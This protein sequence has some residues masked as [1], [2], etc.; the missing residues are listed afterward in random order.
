MFQ[1]AFASMTIQFC[2]WERVLYLTK[3]HLRINTNFVFSMKNKLLLLLFFSLQ[4]FASCQDVFMYIH[5]YTR[6]WIG[7]FTYVKLNNFSTQIISGIYFP[8]NS[9]FENNFDNFRTKK[10]FSIEIIRNCLF[11]LYISKQ[12]CMPMWMCL[13]WNILGCFERKKNTQLVL[14][15]CK[16][17]HYKTKHGRNERSTSPKLGS[18]ET[19]ICENKMIILM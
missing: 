14:I 18:S 17:F 12:M 10:I 16:F 4:C 15:L 19:N 6:L 5:K 11:K 7:S 2:V 1:F 3:L 13:Y 8:Q 9:I